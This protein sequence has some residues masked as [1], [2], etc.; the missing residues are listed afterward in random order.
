MGNFESIP[1]APDQNELLAKYDPESRVRRFAGAKGW[2]VG[3][4][5][6]AFSIYQVV[7]SIFPAPPAQQH[8]S[9]HLA[10]GL[11]AIYL[12]FPPGKRGDRG[13]LPLYDAA[14]AMLAVAAAAYWVYN[15][16]GLISRIGNFSAVDYATGAVV[17]LLV[18]EAARR[19]VG[20]PIVVIASLFLLY[21]L[22][23][24][25]LPGFLQHRGYDWDRVIGQMYF[26][27]EGVFGTPLQV[28]A[29]FIFLF[30]LFGA[31]LER[32]GVGAYF[33]ELSLAIAGRRVGGPAKVTVFSSALQ[34]TISGSSVAN[35]VMSG[36]FTIPMMKRLGY[37]KEFAGGVEAASSTGG[38]IMPP[39][40]GAAAFLMAEFTGIEYWNIALA[41]AIPASLYFAGIW[42]MVHLEARR[43]GLR[44]LN[45][46]EMPDRWEV[47]KR[48][49]LLLPI[50]V[51]I[52]ALMMGASPIRAALYGIA[53]SIAVSF[54]RK[55]TRLSVADFFRTLRDGA[56][57]ALG[58][59]AATA[60]AGMVV[61]TVT[62][63][64]LGL[65]F[66]NGLIDLSG[67]ILL[68]TLFLTMISS[69]L[70]GMGTPTTANY[71]ITATIAA[72]A[73]VQLDVPILAAHMFAFYF[74]IVADITPPVAL[75]A[76]A[77]A[78]IA[79]G[80]PI[81]TG[82][83]SSKLAIAAFLIPYVFVLSPELLLIDAAWYETLFAVLTATVGM[84]GV[85][86]GMIGFWF[87]PMRWWERVWAAAAG[88]M[89]IVPGW[90]TDSIG[91]GSL[92]VIALMQWADIRRKP[93]HSNATQEM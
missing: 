9:I 81:R 44:G 55:D 30:L 60:A 75:A 42:I 91:F 92:L 47:L 49:Y 78:G 68:L 57:S 7:F 40:M 16:D 37:R 80:G 35:V 64:G 5:L 12:L 6:V 19:V 39:I 28:S 79:G 43:T 23:G 52:V 26:T 73:L 74:G 10:F 1:S 62:L 25:F 67:G 59:V 2:F 24:G 69:I 85:G 58:V 29:K 76:F 54:F 8:L 63:T 89:L 50:V 86:A 27:T 53:S 38:Q 93:G 32:T 36:A 82:I 84:F 21:A 66:A 87:R 15:F 83:E 71:I 14:L 61:G 46:E 33:N 20:V 22:F 51:I 18:L 11:G 90:I 48:S 34:G 41:A 45:D 88:L 31:F 17:V 70:L 3:A 77:A 65:K 72:P 13:K 56:R 4:W